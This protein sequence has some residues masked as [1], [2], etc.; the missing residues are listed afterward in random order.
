A[1]IKAISKK[2]K[3]VMDQRRADFLAGAV[4]RGLAPE[5][6]RDIWD[7]IVV[8]AA[9]GF[10]KAHSAAYA[11][12][13][14]YTAYLKAHYA[15]EFFAALLSS[16]IEDGNKRDIMVQHIDDARRFGVEV[17]PPCV[18]ASEPEFS[19]AGGKVVFA[20]MAVK[21]F[22]RA[23]SEEVLRA[24]AGGGPFRDLF[25]FCERIDARVVSRAAIEKLIKAG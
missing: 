17:L 3:E 14:Y 8:F 22:G 13:S 7:K 25:D 12:L 20:L 24:R 18:N 16:E 21:G 10:N 1:C 4:E 23:A 6:A 19:V 15:P 2:N 5:A 9:Y 11:K